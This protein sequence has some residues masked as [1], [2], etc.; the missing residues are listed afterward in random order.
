MIDSEDFLHCDWFPYDTACQMH[1]VE[2]TFRIKHGGY[3][4]VSTLRDINFNLYYIQI[5]LK[6]EDRRF[7]QEFEDTRPTI[8]GP[9]LIVKTFNAFLINKVLMTM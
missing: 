2:L 4:L 6:E 9:L 8:L 3:C 7:T 1:E 5:G